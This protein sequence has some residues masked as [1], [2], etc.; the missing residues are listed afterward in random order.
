MNGARESAVTV[1]VGIRRHG[2]KLTVMVKGA[3]FPREGKSAPSARARER[4]PRG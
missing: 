4:R 1:E 3:F 2:V